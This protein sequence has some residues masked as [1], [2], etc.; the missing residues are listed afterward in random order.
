M[1]DVRYAHDDAEEPLLEDLDLV[2]ERARGLRYSA[3]RNGEGTIMRLATGELFPQSG[4]VRPGSNVRLAYQ[5]QQLARLDDAKTILQEAMDATGFDAPG[6]R[7]SRG[8]LFS[9][10]DVFKKVRSLSGASETA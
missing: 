10:E 8:V 4:M 3:Q 2:V 9:G 6:P 7:T 5:D 1:E